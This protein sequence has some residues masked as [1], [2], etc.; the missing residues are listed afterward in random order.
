LQMALLSQ[1][2][3]DTARARTF[4]SRAQRLKAKT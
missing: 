3:G 4:K 1:K 2:N